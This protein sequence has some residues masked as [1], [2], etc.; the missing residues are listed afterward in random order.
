MK[1]C[2]LIQ[3]L[4][5]FGFIFLF[6][7]NK[8]SNSII[9]DNQCSDIIC[10]Q[11]LNDFLV[12]ISVSM[13]PYDIDNLNMITDSENYF[14]VSSEATNGYD[15]DYDILESPNTPG[16]WISLYFPHPEWG[17]PLGENFTQDI[18]GNIISI[19]HDR[20]IEWNFN[21]E[22]NAYGTI[23][24]NFEAIDDYCYG[25]IKSIQLITEEQIYTTNDITFKNIN[26]SSFLEQ[27]QILS[28][29]LR[30]EFN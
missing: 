23:N 22:S 3:Y 10:E 30:I 15:T 12:K 24:L 18:R 8:T 28:F 6:Q 11:N 19:E 16:N 7:C 9:N 20:T 17:N 2:N 27:N 21:I 25:C 5:I 26:I 4:F 1:K 13:T 14:G 29:N